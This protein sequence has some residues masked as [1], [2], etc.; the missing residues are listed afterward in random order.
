MGTHGRTGLKRL[1]LGSVAGKDFALGALSGADYQ[2]IK[3]I[4]NFRETL[5][6]VRAYLT[7]YLRVSHHCFRG[8]YILYRSTYTFRSLDR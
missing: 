8:S 7:H 3:L 2:E 6:H 4:K 1:V 5:T